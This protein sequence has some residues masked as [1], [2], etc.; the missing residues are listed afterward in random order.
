MKIRMIEN[1]LITKMV[2]KMPYNGQPKGDFDKSLFELE[3]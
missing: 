3:M 2:K 1:K